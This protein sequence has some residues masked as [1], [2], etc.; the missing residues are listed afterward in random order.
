MR[1]K[2]EELRNP[3]P[4]VIKGDEVWLREIYATFDQKK[5]GEG[6]LITG[7]MT[8]TP[9]DYGVYYLEGELAYTPSVPCGR[10]VDRIPWEI[11]RSFSLRFLTPYQDEESDEPLEKDL[12][13]E[14]LDDYYI[15]NKEI[16]IEPVLNDLIQTALPTR[17]IKTT[18]D[19]KACA[20]CLEDIEKPLVYEQQSAADASPFA[21]LKKLKLPE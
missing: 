4:I 18:A 13:P 1:F 9:A 19:G 6:P 8:L 5:P 20:I 21:V 2:V 15:E 10:C 12:T 11:K 7:E 17:L 3:V 14:D 16:D